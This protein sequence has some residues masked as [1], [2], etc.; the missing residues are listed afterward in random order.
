[1]LYYPILWQELSCSL[2]VDRPLV[3]EDRRGRVAPHSNADCPVAT[4]IMLLI[5]C[6]D[7]VDT[8]A[9]TRSDAARW[10]KH[11]WVWIITY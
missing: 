10:P 7:S 1:M 5:G 11:R 2:Y 6:A 3:L 8:P 4:E 9:P